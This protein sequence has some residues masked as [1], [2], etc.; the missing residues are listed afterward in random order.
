MKLVI[1][2]HVCMIV[3]LS[4]QLISC[5]QKSKMEPEKAALGPNKGQANKNKKTTGTPNKNQPPNSESKTCLEWSAAKM[6]GGVLIPEASGLAVSEDRSKLFHIDDSGNPAYIHVTANDGKKLNDVDLTNAKNID[7]EALASGPCPL[8]RS[9]C[10]Y[11]ADIGDNRKKRSA[12]Q[13]YIVQESAL[14]QPQANSH[15]LQFTYDDGKSHNA[16]GAAM[17]PQGDLFIF[18]KESSTRVYRVSKK[19]LSKPQTVASYM[20]SLPSDTAT[21]ADIDS[22]GQ[23]LVILDYVK[24]T[25]YQID[26]GDIKSFEN[27]RFT[28]LPLSIQRQQEA[29]AYRSN[30]EIIYTSEQEQNKIGI[31]T[32]TKK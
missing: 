24:A 6:T 17:S 8:E 15:T 13:I 32:C 14:S 19:D 25:E 3:L 11:V 30:T 10:L 16:E 12:Y 7:W 22:T 28:H 1:N 9:R 21:G 2:P 31:V 27:P 18:T 29:I 5:L 4:I 23:H 20:G 26:L